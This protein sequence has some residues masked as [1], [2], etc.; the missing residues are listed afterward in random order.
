MQKTI[1]RC[2]CNYDLIIFASLFGMPNWNMTNTHRDNIYCVCVGNLAYIYGVCLYIFS[3]DSITCTFCLV[4]GSWCT[5][6]NGFGWSRLCVPQ[7][8]YYSCMFQVCV[9]TSLLSVVDLF[10]FMDCRWLLVYCDSEFRGRLN[11]FHPIIT[12]TD[13]LLY[14]FSS[15]SCSL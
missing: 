14:Y 8:R 1:F 13:F 15:R 3:S 2:I 10:L 11:P 12:L 9:L 4:I 7:H 5:Y 6:L